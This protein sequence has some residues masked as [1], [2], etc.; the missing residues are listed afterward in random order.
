MLQK[1]AI[2]GR[3]LFLTGLAAFLLLFSCVPS[4]TPIGIAAKSGLIIHGTERL[5]E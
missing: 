3:V 5:L 4:K 2:R 1:D